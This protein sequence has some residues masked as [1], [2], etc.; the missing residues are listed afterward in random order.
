MRGKLLVLITVFMITM[1]VI[2]LLALRAWLD[3]Q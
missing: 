1:Y 3:A 2:A